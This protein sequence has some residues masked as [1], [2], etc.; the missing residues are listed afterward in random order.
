MKLHILI[1]Y[2]VHYDGPDG[3]IGWAYW[4]RAE[5]LKKCA[6]PDMEIRIASHA[7]AHELDLKNF[8]LLFML[9][10]QS[11]LG[12]R[13]RCNVAGIPFIVSFNKDHRSRQKEFYDVIRVADL[14]IINN[15]AR[16]IADGIQPKTVN[17]SNGVD[18]ETFRVL[19]GFQRELKSLWTGGTGAAK[20]K[21]YHEVIVPLQQY[22]NRHGMVHSFRPVTA[23]DPDQVLGTEKQ[24]AW[25]NRGTFVLNA[26]ASEGTPCT[27]LEGMA[28]GCIPITTEVGNVPEIIEHQVN[29]MVVDR[30]GEGFL[31]GIEYAT[32]HRERMSQAALSSI[33]KW[34]YGPPGNRA[35]Y[36]YSLFRKVICEGADSVQPFSYMDVTPGEI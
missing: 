21:G 33:R 32:K 18:L 2:D 4:R 29:G 15:F 12:W 24:V 10:Y 16:Y 9:D 26:S 8:S 31:Q 23:I 27:M 19:P 25:Y 30:T 14:T 11:A 36:F 35:E 13:H 5:A 3:R 22:M 28:C 17:I 34:G 7:E 6:P 1:V 20:L